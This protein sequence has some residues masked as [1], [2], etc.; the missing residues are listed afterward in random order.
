MAWPNHKNPK[1]AARRFPR[2]WFKDGVAYYECLD[3]GTV[4]HGLNETS[5]ALMCKGKKSL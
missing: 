4:D 5:H 2:R 3:C 1:P